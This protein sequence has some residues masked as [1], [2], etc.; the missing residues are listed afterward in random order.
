MKKSSVYL[1]VLAV[2]LSAGV[3]HAQNDGGGHVGGGDVTELDFQNYMNKIDSFLM[4]RAGAAAFPE[5]DWENFHPLVSQI[6]PRVQHGEVLDAFGIART[7]VSHFEDEKNRYFICNLDELPPNTI[8]NEPKF[9]RITFH[10]LLVQ[11]GIEK[12]LS[13]DVPSEYS[14]SARIADHLQLQVLKEWKLVGKK[15]N[16]VHGSEENVQGSVV[17]NRLTGEMLYLIRGKGRPGQQRQQQMG[18]DLLDPSENRGLIY[19]FVTAN[20]KHVELYLG[21]DDLKQFKEVILLL[22]HRQEVQQ[23]FEEI[24][25]LNTHPKKNAFSKWVDQK[26]KSS[27]LTYDQVMGVVEQLLSGSVSNLIPIPD[28]SFAA[29]KLMIQFLNE[30]NDADA[31]DIADEVKSVKTQF[32]LIKEEKTEE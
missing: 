8:E 5:I 22:Q 6:H 16:P 32:G 20:E 29:V 15:A 19:G 18:E 25:K 14:L 10:E 12:P 7:C 17:Q 2:L 27:E 4:T 1:G 24:F 9:Y 28:Q 30:S 26:F 23:L 13:K 11:A 3:A 21:L 31:E